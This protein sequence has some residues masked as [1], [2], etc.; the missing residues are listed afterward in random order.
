[1]NAADQLECSWCGRYLHRH[2]DAYYYGFTPTGVQVIDNVLCSVATA[3][4]RA[5]HRGLE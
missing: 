2:F 5:P 3:G 1:M 4:M